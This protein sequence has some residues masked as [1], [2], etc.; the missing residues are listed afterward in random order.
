[1]PLILKGDTTGLLAAVDARQVPGRAPTGSMTVTTWPQVAPAPAVVVNAAGTRGYLPQTMAHGLGLN[2]QFDNTVFPK[3]S[4]MN[5]D[6]NQHQ[7]AEHISL[8]EKD[9]PVGLPWDVA[10]TNDDRELWVVNAASN[11]V[12]VLDISDPRAVRRTAHIPVADNPRGIVM[13]PDGGRAYVNNTLAGTVSV[14]DTGQ[15]TVTAV[16]T[17]TE[18]PLPPVLLHGKRLFHSSSLPELSQARW[19]SCNTCH[20]EGEHDGRTWLL[21]Y[22][23]EVPPGATAVITRNTTS[24]LGMIETYPLRWSAEWDESADSEFSVRFE[25]FGTGL[26]VGEM[27]PT[28]GAP[29][30][31]RSWDLDC[32]AAYVDSLEVGHSRTSPLYSPLLTTSAS[33]SG[34]GSGVR[35]DPSHGRELFLSARTQCS[36]CHPAPLYTDQ[37]QHDVGTASSYGEWFGPLIDTPS[38]RFVYDSAPYLH[39]GSAAT[40][41]EVLTTAN[42]DD[43]HGVTS[44][45]TAQEL[46]DLVAYMLG[47]PYPAEDEPFT[48]AASTCLS[49]PTRGPARI[50]IRVEGHD[51]VMAH[52]GA[53]Y[54]CCAQ[55]VIYLQDR[56][57]LFK[58]VEQEEYPDSEPCRCLCPYQLGA[59][60]ANLPAGTYGVQVWD[61]TTDTLLAEERVT[62]K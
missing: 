48:Y 56:S 51:I 42:A 24:L 37:R 23:G 4:V 41:L 43:Q 12:S 46:D 50:D 6:T 22:T 16:I 14:I 57:P 45:L 5:L 15:Y 18:I 33:S 39:D 32:L 26:I 1:M 21:Q 40:L 25:Q 28:L 53:I 54:N 34:E 38:L 52:D 49:Q 27:N 55:M 20:I 2:T 35:S 61:G 19:I 60:I 10:L 11:D 3:V 62:V 59:R 31:G 17:V 58:L 44:H 30:Q 7:T 8:P 9:Q 29:N 13:H 47:L 36:L